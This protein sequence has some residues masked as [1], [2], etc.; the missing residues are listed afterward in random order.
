MAGSGLRTSGGLI[1][2]DALPGTETPE[3]LVGVED[4][5]GAAADPIAE[6][7]SAIELDFTVLSSALGFSVLLTGWLL[8]FVEVAALAADVAVLTLAG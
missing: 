2:D 8:G 1:F 3:L 5:T 7:D 6:L 4:E